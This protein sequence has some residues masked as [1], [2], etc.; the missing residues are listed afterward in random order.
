MTEKGT[1]SG[2]TGLTHCPPAVR[3]VPSGQRLEATVVAL[4]CVCDFTGFCFCWVVRGFEAVCRAGDEAAGCE[5]LTSCTV[6]KAFPS[7][8]RAQPIAVR[9]VHLICVD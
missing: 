4:D 9:A 3:V 7:G 8:H 5:G 6:A 1:A 2:E